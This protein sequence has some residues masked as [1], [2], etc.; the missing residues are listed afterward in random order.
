MAKA[1]FEDI[2]Q[3]SG[4]ATS[5]VQRILRHAMTYRI[6]CEPQE[7]VVFHTA[8]SKNLAT[9]PLLHEWIGMV[10]EEMWPAASKACLQPLRQGCLL[11]TGM[12]IV[13]C[14]DGRGIDEVAGL[15]RI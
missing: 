11:T 13:L 10:S 1:S 3:R 2:A 4:L 6:F 7:G 8:A 12:L 15:I 9:N 5:H 14:V